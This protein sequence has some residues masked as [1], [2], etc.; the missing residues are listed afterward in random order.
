V[1]AITDGSTIL[2]HPAAQDYQPAYV[3]DRCPNTGGIGAHC[4]TPVI[5]DAFRGG[6]ARNG[7]PGISRKYRLIRNSLNYL[8][9]W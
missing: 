8:L 2:T 9:D 4:P 6:I 3:G 7:P 1:L 5:D